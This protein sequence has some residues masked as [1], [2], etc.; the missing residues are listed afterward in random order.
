V[1]CPDEGWV[2]REAQRRGSANSQMS[3]RHGA[4]E[5]RCEAARTPRHLRAERELGDETMFAV[6]A[7]AAGRRSSSEIRRLHAQRASWQKCAS[8]WGCR[9]RLGRPARARRRF[10]IKLL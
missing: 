8:I 6:E 10:G 7:V 5:T 1:K 9:M 2:D 4:Q 3:W